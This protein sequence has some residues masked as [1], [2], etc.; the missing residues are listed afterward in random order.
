[1]TSQT[2]SLSETQSK[3]PQNYILIIFY[4]PLEVGVILGDL[5][6]K[7]VE[8]QIWQLKPYKLLPG[9]LAD[10]KMIKCF[11]GEVDIEIKYNC[12]RKQF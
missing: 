2:Q 11:L 5:Q 1:M 8:E 7:V 9:D 4:L 10:Q 6:E 3:R 12:F